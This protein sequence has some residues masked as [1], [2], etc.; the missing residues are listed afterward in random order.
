MYNFAGINFMRK[1][2]SDEK[3]VEQIRKQDHLLRRMWWLGPVGLLVMLYCLIRLADIVEGLT[4]HL[5]LERKLVYAGLLLGV[6]FGLLL[7]SIA[8]QTGNFIKHW[9][10]TRHGF[11]TERLMLKYH[12]ELMYK[13][14]G[15]ASHTTTAPT[16][17]SDSASPQG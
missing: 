4:A 15:Q 14:P 16:L 9:I 3:Y 13:T 1:P 17:G 7:T 6:S 8:V 5:Q 12:D 11:R 10:D 2:I